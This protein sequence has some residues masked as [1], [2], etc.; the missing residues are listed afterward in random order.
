MRKDYDLSRAA[1]EDL[2]AIFLDGVERFGLNQAELYQDGLENSFAFLAQYPEATR[3][4]LE[5]NPPS[6]A[7]PYRAHMIFYRIAGSR[8]F[9]QRIRHAREDWLSRREN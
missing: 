7:Y 5:L 8:I 1:V 3:E 6:R 9:I 2:I 4:R